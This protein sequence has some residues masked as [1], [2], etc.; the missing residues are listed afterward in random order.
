MKWLEKK[1]ALPATAAVMLGI[2]FAH[3]SNRPLSW[4]LGFLGLALLVALFSFLRNH[5][6]FFTTSIL[7]ALFLLG[8]ARLR[9]Q[10]TLF[11]E[12]HITVF[13]DL[14][15]T[16]AVEGLVCKP[17]LAR[18]E[19]LST[20]VDVDSIWVMAQKFPAD[21]RCLLR[22]YQAAPR[23]KYGD[24]IV[25]RG[26]LRSPRG[27]RNPGEFNYRNYLAAQNI[28]AVL[29]VNSV[30]HV[31]LLNSKEGAFLLRSF[32]YPVRRFVVSFIDAS[33]SGQPAALL[34]ALL[35]GARGDID[36]ELRKEFAN[37]G[38]IH[39]LAVSGL[40]VGFILAGL[41]G[42]FSFL[43]IRD[44]WRTVLTMIGL[45]F[46][47]WLTG[48]SPSV[49]RASVMAI[50]LLGGRLLQR[51]SDILNS[52]AVAAFIILAIQPLD[53]F[54]PGF[55]LSFAAVAGIVLL[56]NRFTQIFQPLFYSLHEKGLG[57]LNG[58]VT[59]FFVSLAAQAAT[60]P[61][62]AYYFGRLPIVSLL[63]NLVVVP[64]VAV[65]VSLG[66]V[67]VL[68]GVISFP[69]GALFANTVWLLLTVLI[70]IVKTA[71]KLPFAYLAVARPSFWFIAFYVLFLFL[72]VVWRRQ[73]VR[74]VF[75][76]ATLILATL[77]VWTHLTPAS[78]AVKI[79]F[80]D[81]G[82]GDAALLQFP[83]GK[84]ML[85]D[86]GDCTDY[87]NNGERVILPYLQR[88]GVRRIDCLL[89]S[90]SHSDHIGGAPSIIKN[91]PVGRLVESGC[92]YP[93]EF[94]DAI[95][96]LAF[97]YNIP[98]TIAL[99]GDTL[100]LDPNVEILVL[101]PTKEIIKSVEE[102]PADL[103]NASVVVQC[104]YDGSAALFVGDAE[105]PAEKAMLRFGVLLRS[106]V[107]KVGH[108]G[109][110]TASSADFRH[111]VSPRLAVVSVAKYNRFGLPSDSLL[112]QF[113][114]DGA[115]VIRT[116]DAGAVQLRMSASGV[117]RLR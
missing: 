94:S 101:H 45:L 27:E 83:N 42:L 35:V 117:Q 114:L 32:V 75:V 34:K 113:A 107:L 22:L 62:T 98:K 36:S 50:V 105:A 49:F 112:Q 100:L 15:C 33:M 1:P 46:Y 109:S 110:R 13:A 104:R 16:V 84:T 95:D 2:F 47:A 20:V 48:L 81:V 96:S 69:V 89:L 12:H 88:Q 55:Q 54:Q 93:S 41:L 23:L 87:V 97:Y 74:K 61:L 25:V 86:A 30:R 59:L 26:Q 68:A 38:V 40:H 92:A 11:P 106:D 18:A 58:I 31:L 82:Q 115:E 91:M 111:A 14:P 78:P 99:A 63:A 37:V 28:H 76:F 6:L 10:T 43:R 102:N 116:S 5:S 67:A 29:S 77:L 21:G 70:A 103:N 17:V 60:L 3:F 108:H 73:K 71:A 56:Y 90:H 4:L 24:R 64:L 66:L 44:P 8:A 85:I 79:T 9:M 52:L 53:L 51:R 80:F 65:I 57:L 19:G 72:F 39:V 7:A